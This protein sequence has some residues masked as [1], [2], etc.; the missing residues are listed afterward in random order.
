RGLRD[1]APMTAEQIEELVGRLSGRLGY[2]REQAGRPPRSLRAHLKAL[3][4]D[5]KHVGEVRARLLAGV[6]APGVLDR[7][8]ALR[9]AAFPAE[10]VLL[11]DEKR[12]YDIRRDEEAKL[13]GLPVW[14]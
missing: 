8:S 9:I 2:A 3:A 1:D 10:Q 7:V 5:P 11:L 6:K 12:E 4:A 14:Q 13:L